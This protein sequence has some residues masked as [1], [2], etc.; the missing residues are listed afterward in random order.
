[1]AQGEDA[2]NIGRFES[3][4]NQSG[5]HSGEFF[6]C[7][8]EGRF[9]GRIEDGG[10]E[11]ER[12]PIGKSHEVARGHESHDLASRVGDRQVLNARIEHVECGIHRISIRPSGQ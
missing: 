7:G 4:L 1:M 3:G 6:G 12:T 5:E 9:T 10:A 11:G 8:I 2:S